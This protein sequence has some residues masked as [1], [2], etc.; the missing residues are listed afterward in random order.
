MPLWDRD[1]TECVGQ[2][3]VGEKNVRSHVLN[4]LLGPARTRPIFFTDYTS[5]VQSGASF[6]LEVR[7]QQA[8]AGRTVSTGHR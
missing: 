7:H 3:I 2:E 8:P 1:Q 5:T 4:G 6:V